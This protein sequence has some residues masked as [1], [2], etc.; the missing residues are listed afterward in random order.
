MTKPEHPVV[1][2]LSGICPLCVV[3]RALVPQEDEKDDARLL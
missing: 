3:Y 2:M 1:D